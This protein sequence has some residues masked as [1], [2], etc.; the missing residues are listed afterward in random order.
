[1]SNI[2]SKK[3]LLLVVT[4]MGVFLVLFGV[5]YAYFTAM[6][7]S[8]EQ[9][10]E[11]GTLVLTYHTGKNI[12]LENVNPTEEE[13]AGIHQF[14]IENTGTLDATYYMYL[15]NITLKKGETNA[16]SEN[17]KWKLYKANESYVE[18][19]EIANGNFSDGNNTIE[20]N[21]NI[22]IEPSEKQYYILKIWLQETGALQNEDQG[23]IFSGQV[24]ATTEKKAVNKSLANLMKQEAVL[25]NIASTYVTSDTGID[26][27]QISSDTNGKG[28]YTLHGTES[29]PNPIMYY[30]G[31]VENNNVKFANFCW[32]IVRTTETGGVKL[33]V[34]N[35]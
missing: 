6:A 22:A 34:V 17:L 8:S 27:S 32:K 29:N 14:A 16:Q 4:I 21:T 9:K 35:V 19:E 31:D 20:M 15:D 13:N 18:Q 33:K 28:L 5:S 23:L 25:D 1:M 12:S 10:V 30:R 2:K 24:V 3:V 11:S 7:T 26:F